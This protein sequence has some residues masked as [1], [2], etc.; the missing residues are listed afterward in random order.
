MSKHVMARQ[1]SLRCEESVSGLYSQHYTS[2]IDQDSRVIS[3]CS[4]ILVSYHPEDLN[5]Y[6]V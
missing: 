4:L 1:V 5:K 2:A 6:D 3:V